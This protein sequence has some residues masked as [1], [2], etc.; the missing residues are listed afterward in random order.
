[1]QAN[2][3]SPVCTLLWTLRLFDSL[4]VLSHTL[5][6]YGFSPGWILMWYFNELGYSN[7][8]PHFK[9]L[10]FSSLLWTVSCLFSTDTGLKAFTQLGDSCSISPSSAKSPLTSTTLV[11]LCS[12]SENSLTSGP[13]SKARLVPLFCQSSWIIVSS[14]VLTGIEA[15]RLTGHLKDFLWFFTLVLDLNTFLQSWHWLS[16]STWSTFF[17][18]TPFATNFSIISLS[19]WLFSTLRLWKISPSLTIF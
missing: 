12:E 13:S 4:N 16:R 19:I 1:V 6:L 10:N 17:V 9:Q 14:N 2:G 3:F 8:S 7:F 5:H 11:F 18:F 15:N